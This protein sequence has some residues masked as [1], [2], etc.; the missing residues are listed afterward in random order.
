MAAGTAYVVCATHGCNG[1]LWANRLGK[2]HYC[3]CGKEWQQSLVANGM[4]YTYATASSETSAESWAQ[5]TGGWHPQGWHAQG[6][7]AHWQGKA[8]GSG[9]PKGPP[10]PPAPPLPVLEAAKALAAAAAASARGRQEDSDALMACAGDEYTVDQWKHLVAAMLRQHWP[11]MPAA[12]RDTLLPVL[13][14][15][16]PEPT[17][18]EEAKKVWKDFKEATAKQRSLSSRKLALQVKADKAKET[19]QQLV[20]D[21]QALQQ[22]L[23]DHQKVV[24]EIGKQYEEKVIRANLLEPP[25]PDWA[26]AEV[27][28]QRVAEATD[29]ERQRAQSQIQAMQAELQQQVAGLKATVESMQ[30]QQIEK[31]AKISE[32]LQAAGEQVPEAHRSELEKLLSGE[33]SKR[34]R[35]AGEGGDPSAVPQQG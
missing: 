20:K 11:A 18:L 13:H 33:D 25:V 31:D 14:T 9:R 7:S 15:E 26:S 3:R 8:G 2:T 28:G 1:W 30:Q 10:P 12:L 21:C 16:P 34:R 22:E 27:V 4:S 32:W 23:D 29:Q 19:W 35:V 24:E 17:A 6:W 5:Q